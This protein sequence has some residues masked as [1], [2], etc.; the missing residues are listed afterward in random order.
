[1][2]KRKNIGLFLTIGVLIV[3]LGLLGWFLLVIFEGE[4]PHIQIGPLPEY[5][6]GDHSF[7]LKISD[8]RRG[9]KSVTVLLSQEGREVTVFEK[10]FPFKGLFNRDGVNTF[11]TAFNVDPAALN[12]AQGRVDLQVLV[13]DYSRRS[14][15]DGNLSLVEHNMVVDTVPPAI[16]AVSRLHYINV[17][18]TGL[19]VYQTSSD[20]RESGI[21]VNDMFFQG[22]RAKE[23]SGQGF[24]VCYFAVACN[25]TGPRDVY[26]WAKDRAGNESRAGFY[27]HVRRKHFRKEKINITERFLKRILPYFS[28]YPLDAQSTDIEK[29]LKINRDLRQ[30]N[31]ETLSELRTKT[32][33]EKL[34]EGPFLR[35][36]NAATMARFGDRRDYYYEGEKIDEQIHMGVDLASLAH[37]EVQAANKGRVV[38]TDRLGIYGQTVVLDHGQGVASVYSHLSK[39]DVEP[40]Q[41][42]KKG[43]RLGLTGQTGLAG[44]DHLH[45]GIMVGGVPVEPI[46]WWDPHWIEDNITRKLAL[47]NR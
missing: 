38:F 23:G 14:G 6:S 15:G 45:F 33:P 30:E 12:L 11:E 35:M 29:F 46:E 10:K 18:G 1:M 31:N 21:Y 26:L 37:S 9:L 27:Y 44:G 28:F 34:W 40:G 13:R 39:I 8:K 47:L 20:T 19:V 41:E 5:L 24:H 16:R 7:V 42:L 25:K 22:F 4:K 32:S 3:V 2:G 17:G 36:H 43:D